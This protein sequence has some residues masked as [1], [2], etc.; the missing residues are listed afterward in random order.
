VRVRQP[1]FSKACGKFFGARKQITSKSP[2]PFKINDERKKSVTKAK[3]GQ[4]S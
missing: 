1:K 3:P 2:K 4:I